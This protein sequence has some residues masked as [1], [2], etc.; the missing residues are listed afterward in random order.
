MHNVTTPMVVLLVLVSL[1]LSEMESSA[2]ISMNVST[3]HVTP[4]QAVIT[5]VAILN[6]I[7]NKVIKVMVILVVILMNTM[8]AILAIAMP[9]VK[10]LLDHTNVHVLLTSLVMA[11]HALMSTNVR[12]RAT[13]VI[14]IK[15]C[16]NTIG[17]FNCVCECSVGWEGDDVTCENIAETEGAIFECPDNSFKSGVGDLDEDECSNGIHGCSVHSTCLN[18][19][20][21]FSC[22]CI[23]GL[24]AMDS[25]VITSMTASLDLIAVTSMPFATT[26]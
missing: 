13:C 17:S 3:T 9:G 21:S 11:V 8:V 1:V 16:F 23:S 10:I 26:I 12:S 4:M 22:T 24:L 18:S 7:M 6:V 15:A 14:K 2:S 19:M 25:S 5:A 20:G